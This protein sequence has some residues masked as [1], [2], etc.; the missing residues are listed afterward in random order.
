LW[1]RQFGSA[2]REGNDDTLDSAAADSTG[3]FFAGRA[4]GTLEDGSVPGT[5]YLRKYDRNG[6]LLWTR[7]TM[8]FF[9]RVA[10]AGGG[11]Y[12]VGTTVQ[13][14]DWHM[15]VRKFDGSGNVP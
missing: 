13:G 7:P 15:L 8:G 3:L 5:Y 9:P 11:V 14:A 10:T 4:A 6:N 2:E 12:V 1:T